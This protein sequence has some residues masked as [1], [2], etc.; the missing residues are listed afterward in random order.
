MYKREKNGL[1]PEK[2]NWS[3]NE[4]IGMLVIICMCF[5]GFWLSYMGLKKDNPKPENTPDHMES[6]GWRKPT[7]SDTVKKEILPPP[8][9]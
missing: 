7:P 3:R 6:R 5:F 9:N 1:P 4:R 2:I 8:D